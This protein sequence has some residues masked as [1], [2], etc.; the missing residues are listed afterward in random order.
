M[1]RA[2][3]VSASPPPRHQKFHLFAGWVKL[4]L[5]LIVVVLFGLIF[6]WPEFQSE[7]SQL[8]EIPS[9]RQAQNEG[10]TSILRGLHYSGYDKKNRPFQISA[11]SASQ[12]K[13]KDEE[14]ELKQPFAE[15][16]LE[17]GSLLA[18]TA[19][20]GYYNRKTEILLLVGAVN[21]LHGEEFEL[22]THQVHVDLQVG[23]AE[24]HYSV[25]AISPGGRLVSEGLR[26]EDQGGRIFF[27]GHSRLS[28]YSKN[29]MKNR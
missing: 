29:R 10:E 7:N 12:D 16:E 21:I 28:L 15:L 20:S 13:D 8:F 2:A 24:G 22:R 27:T 25:E 3:P 11:V 4:A 9:A 23:S 14:I 26:I 5:P 6:F 1:V 17:D 19:E 18:V